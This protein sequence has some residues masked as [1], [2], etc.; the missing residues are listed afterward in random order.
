MTSE[1]M[2]RVARRLLCSAMLLG[3]VV[4]CDDGDF[5]PRV[6]SPDWSTPQEVADLEVRGRLAMVDPTLEPAA[7]VRL[8]N[9]GTRT[10]RVEVGSGACA[11]ELRGYRDRGAEPP[12]WQPQRAVCPPAS[13]REVEVEGGETEIITVEVPLDAE[14]HSL[15]RRFRWIVVMGRVRIDG[16]V[17]DMELGELLR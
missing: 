9:T 11:I 4:A 17:V 1:K 3:T 13:T 8:R 14:L 10:V 5:V 15:L 2:T 12:V 16:Q 6:S 7:Q